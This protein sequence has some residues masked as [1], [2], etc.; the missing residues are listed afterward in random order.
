MTNVDVGASYL[1]DRRMS[2]AR[3]WDELVEEVRGIDGFTDFLKPP[4]L[5]T[6]LPAAAEGPVAVINV[7]PWRCD[8]LLVRTD[9]VQVVELSGVSLRALIDK[10]NEYLHVLEAVDRVTF[11]L[12]LARLDVENSAPVPA[13]I[14]R[15]TDAKRDLQ[16]AAL[17]RDATLRALLRWLWDQIAEPV[18]TALGLMQTPPP[19]Q[20]WPRLWWCPTGPLTL[21]PLHAAG[22]HDE[23]THT[24]RS[25]LDRVVSSYTPTLRALIEARRPLDPHP[26]EDRILVVAVPDPPGAVPLANVARER[27]LLTS[28]FHARHTVLEGA[29]ATSNAVLTELGRHRWAHFSCHGGQDLTDPSRGALRMHDGGLTVTDISAQR[30]AG[31]FAFLSACMTAVGGVNLPDEA[32]TLAAAVHYTGFRHVIGT[33]WS[34]YDDTAAEITEAVYAYLT[35]TGQFDPSRAARALHAAVRR[36]RDTRKLP[37]SDWTPFTHTGP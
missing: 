26:D 1:A 3:E 11:E 27:T 25:V 5:E 8:A 13:A 15:Y 20:E 36:I 16:R 17:D 24:G 31:E 30:H 23:E 37:P 2:L 10:A 35:S 6:L 21:L 19:G 4:R 33:L 34:V 18:L 7:S 32:I 12:Y 29:C 14:R 28:L 22:Y 9:G